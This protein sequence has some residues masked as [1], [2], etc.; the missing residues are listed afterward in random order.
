MQQTV[1]QAFRPAVKDEIETGFSA[2]VFSR[3][4][5]TR[6]VMLSSFSKIFA[7]AKYLRFDGCSAVE[8]AEINLG[9]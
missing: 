3:L 8:M 9:G 4:V 5:V 6:T 2:E 1:E 7:V